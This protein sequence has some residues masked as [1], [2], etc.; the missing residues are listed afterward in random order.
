M[1]TS[2]KTLSR[3][4]AFH[5]Q[6][7]LPAGG[8]IVELGAQELYCT[9]EEEH[10]REVIAYFHGHLPSIRPPGDYSRAELTAFAD[11][12]MLGNLLAACGFRY[13]ALDIF[14]APN[15]RLF[16]LNV[17]SPGADLAGQFDLVTNYGTTE[18]VVNQYLSM[19]TMHELARPGGLIHHD[20][21][22]AGYHDHGYFCYNPRFFV[23]LA[24]SNG[25]EVAFEAYSR[26]ATATPAPGILV[27]HGFP[28]RAY[29]D[30]GI[31]FALRKVSDAAFRLP[32]ETSTSLGISQRFLAPD[33]GYWSIDPPALPAQPGR[34]PDAVA[35]APV[36]VL[37]RELLR[38]YRERLRRLF[39]P[40]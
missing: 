17:E 2:A 28:E 37:H 6:G 9:G 27:R 4:I 30:A 13:L 3:L 16:D 5:H 25:Y 39:A 34:P 22:M 10:L 31:E 15:T 33:S 19:K 36:S 29:H 38:R 26:S 32:L 20:L 1:G 21:P 40:G 14:E 35:R 18:H 24:E 11:R 23:E 12:G 8:S 7:L